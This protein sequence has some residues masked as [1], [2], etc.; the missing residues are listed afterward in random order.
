MHMLYEQFSSLR[1]VQTTVYA[2]AVEL[3]PLI[4]VDLAI[5]A[6]LRVEFEPTKIEAQLARP[7]GGTRAY[8]PRQVHSAERNRPT[9]AILESLKINNWS[10]LQ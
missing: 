5:C 6:N 1:S 8:M 3:S 9:Y 4:S 2:Y 10:M 7:R